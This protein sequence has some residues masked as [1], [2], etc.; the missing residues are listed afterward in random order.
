MNKLHA[1]DMETHQ[2]WMT[3]P[4]EVKGVSEVQGVVTEYL[5]WLC[6]KITSSYH[7][8]PTPLYNNPRAREDVHNT[9]LANVSLANR[10]FVQEFLTTQYYSVFADKF[11]ADAK[12]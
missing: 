3:T 1:T 9:L 2:P 10:K 12:L 4:E 5:T 8:S 11:I 7:N 6:Q